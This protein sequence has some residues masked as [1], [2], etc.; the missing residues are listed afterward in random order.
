MDN[1]VI[2]EL[3]DV[4]LKQS[5]NHFA[6]ELIPLES[7][8]QIS[9]YRL[10]IKAEGEFIPQ[11]V[12][13]EWKVP[14]IG[15]KGYWRPTADFSKRIEADWELQSHES[16]ISID[17]PVLQLF[18]NK[19]ENIVCFSC[20]NAI[21]RI[22]MAA[23]YREEDNNFYCRFVFFT[24][25]KYPIRNFSADIRIDYRNIHFSQRAGVSPY[26]LII[27]SCDN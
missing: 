22:E 16:R 5:G 14:A 9:L 26:S 17:A 23:K 2:Q 4:V 6:C 8:G 19:D 15:V 21:N 18:G 10:E 11:P 7:D 1:I 24:E 13:V 20:S 27:S 25:C 3:E 12:E